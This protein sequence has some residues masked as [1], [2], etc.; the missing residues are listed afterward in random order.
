MQLPDPF[1]TLNAWYGD[2]LLAKPGRW[3][4]SLSTDDLRLLE[5]TTANYIDQGLHLDAVSPTN[6]LLSDL[7][8]KLAMF[9][10]DLYHGN[11]FFEIQGLPIDQYSDYFSRV[12]LA[13]L[14]SY[15]DKELS[16]SKR[17]EHEL[18]HHQI[19]DDENPMEF[20]LG[21]QAQQIST[22]SSIHSGS[23]LMV[24]MRDQLSTFSNDE[25]LVSGVTLYNEMYTRRKDL[26]LALF[27][28]LPVLVKS[29]R[30]VYR[31]QGV[32]KT[33][34]VFQYRQHVLKFSYPRDAIEMAQD[35]SE[36]PR[37]SGQQL[38]A[39]DFLEYLMQDPS[40]H[41]KMAL[42]AGGI[43]V[44]D[45]NNVF[46]GMLPPCGSSHSFSSNVGFGS[47]NGL[48]KRFT[49]ATATADA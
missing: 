32:I 17:F 19:P 24:H 4:W 9:A 46:H 13:G 47:T 3:I 18:R 5:Q 38:E 23:A 15:F 36:A 20:E 7:E 42:D 16:G 34:H 8:L 41:L 35:C 6:F 40:I 39:L 28:P 29:H 2:D 44:Y 10:D 30:D 11:G 14:V 1:D 12:M 37:L 25:Y 45:Q 48:N 22:L 33:A 27:E 26:L 21:F 31:D 49:E 43:I